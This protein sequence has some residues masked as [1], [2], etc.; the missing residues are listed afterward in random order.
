MPSASRSAGTPRVASSAAGPA[1]GPC[2]GR[3]RAPPGSRGWLSGQGIEAG[4]AVSIKFPDARV[5]LA[6]AT[7]LRE[8]SQGPAGKRVRLDSG[9]LAADVAKQPAGASFVVSTLQADVMVVGTRFS[10]A[11]AA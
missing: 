6:A 2:P 1:S 11:C 4:A 10:V 5:D 8:C 3:G 7:T 9:T